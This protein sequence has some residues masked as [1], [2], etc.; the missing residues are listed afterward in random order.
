MR[1][2]IVY[3][4]RTGYTRRV[5]QALAEMLQADLAEVHC[6]RYRLGYIRY[7]RAAFDSISGLL[8]PIEVP[9]AVGQNYDL[10]IIG[11]PMWTRHPALPIRALLKAGIKLPKRVALFLTR[12]GAPPEQAFAEMEALL[13][14]PAAAKLAVRSSDVDAGRVSEELR[15][16]AAQLSEEKVLASCS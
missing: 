6:D 3:Y 10:V 9:P 5:A 13:P 1:T 7:W 16:F 12:I 11:T 4:S 2:L 8:P 15:V 14:V